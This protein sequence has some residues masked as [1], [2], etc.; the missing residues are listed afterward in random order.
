M[1]NSH[2]RTFLKRL[3]ST[4]MSLDLSNMRLRD[5]GFGAYDALEEEVYADEARTITLKSEGR[6]S[7]SLEKKQ[8]ATTTRPKT[9]KPEKSDRP[10][11]VGDNTL[12]P[13]DN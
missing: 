7:L 5:I 9:D 6:L 1:V 11:P 2:D 3:T 4:N 10:R 13:F 8:R 12:N